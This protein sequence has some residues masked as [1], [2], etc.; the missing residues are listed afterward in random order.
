MF[1]SRVFNIPKEDVVNYFVWRQQDAVRNSIQSAG[2]A[3]FSHKQLMNKSCD[4]IQD[5]IYAGMYDL[6]NSVSV[7][8]VMVYN[9]RI[10]QSMSDD[11]DQQ[12]TNLWN[13]AQ[14][15]YHENFS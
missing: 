7:S 11:E 10:S 13:F 8:S 9:S 15:L 6:E 2:Q 5:I 3:N 4:Q 1:D 12:Y 14:Q